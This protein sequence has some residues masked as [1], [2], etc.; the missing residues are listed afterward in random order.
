MVHAFTSIIKALYRN[1]H[2][3]KIIKNIHMKKYCVLLLLCSV[4]IA[5]FAQENSKLPYSTKSLANENIKNVKASTSGGNITVTG[6]DTDAHIEVFISAN[7]WAKKNLS[8]EEI[9]KRL[10]EDYELTVSVSDET[11]TAIAKP[12]QGYN[13]GKNGLSISFKVFVPHTVSTNLTTSGGNI[14]IAS[15]Q[16]KQNFT[17]SGGNLT[18]DQLSGNIVGRTS[19]GNITLS[20]SKDEIELTTSGG[21]IDASNSNG[22]IKLK[23]SGGDVSMQT[24]NGMIKATTSGGNVNGNLIEGELFASTSGGDVKMKELSCSL[25]ASTSGGNIRI[26]MKALGKYIKLSNSGGDIELQI[27]QE[28]GMDLKLYAEKIKV[29]TFVNF[30]GDVEEHRMEGSLNGGGIPVTV[31]GGNGKINLTLK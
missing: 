3:K 19:G 22:N 24:L 26:D 25:D 13:N 18:V 15:L 31:H 4:G 17:T 23:T 20:N 30:K 28:K 14:N 10:E 11:L 8:T 9:K 7:N 29:N 5:A 16:G 6:V 12:K 1:Y 21:N 2:F 27:P